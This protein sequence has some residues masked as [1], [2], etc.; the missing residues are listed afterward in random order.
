MAYTIDHW[1]MHTSQDGAATINWVQK[2][3]ADAG[4]SKTGQYTY[5]FSTEGSKD[6]T[7]GGSHTEEIETRISADEGVNP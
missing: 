7:G 2:D 1:T 5:D 3:L 4:A 6:W